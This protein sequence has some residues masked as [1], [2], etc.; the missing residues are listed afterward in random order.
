MSEGWVFTVKGDQ[1]N[2]YL[3]CNHKGEV[4]FFKDYD[5]AL[6]AM[7]TYIQESNW[8]MSRLKALRW[9]RKFDVRIGRI[10]QTEIPYCVEHKVCLL[11]V[12]NTQ[13][14][15]WGY[16]LNI[17]GFKL[18]EKEVEPVWTRTKWMTKRSS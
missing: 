12:M 4:E 14:I 7:G 10:R 17:R 9:I 18:R 13:L 8:E 16:K 1:P 5:E 11:Q 6:E 15:C 3:L 2:S